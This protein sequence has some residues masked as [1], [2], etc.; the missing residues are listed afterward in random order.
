V[1]DNDFLSVPLNHRNGDPRVACVVLADVS[2]S[3]SGAPIGALE[4]GFSSFCTYLQEDDLARKRAE[5]G[6]VT[7]GSQAT[8]LVPIQE[9]RT[10]EPAHFEISGSTNMAAGIHM[11]LDMIEARKQDYKD[12]GLEYYRP[13][14]LVFTDGSP[15]NQG[16]SEAVAR[17][18][19]LEHRRGVTVFPIGVGSAVNFT[20]LGELS[21]VRSPAHLDGLKFNELFE[22]LSASLSSVSQSSAH[23]IDGAVEDT[24]QIHL[25][26]PTGWMTA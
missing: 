3:M 14:L 19:Q 10:L 22:W 1:A 9:G 21:G 18:N 5:V 17:L 23:G 6:V 20:R 8:V 13:W 25:P 11:A 16:F 7:F 2:G 4:E 26:A 12:A 15:D 24:Q